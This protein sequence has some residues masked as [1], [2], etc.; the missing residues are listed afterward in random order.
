MLIVIAFYRICSDI[1]WPADLLHV[2]AV[3]LA[4]GLFISAFFAAQLFLIHHIEQGHVFRRRQ[5]PHS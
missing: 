3:F 2:S 5:S 1:Q 4:A